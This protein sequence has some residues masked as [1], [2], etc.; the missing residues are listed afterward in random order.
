VWG[1]RDVEAHVVPLFGIYRQNITPKMFLPFMIVLPQPLPDTM[2][3]HQGKLDKCDFFSRGRGELEVHS[4]LEKG[5]AWAC[6]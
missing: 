4:F 1:R 3:A 2:T 6:R 5:K